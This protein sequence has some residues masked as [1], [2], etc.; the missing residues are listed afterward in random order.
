MQNRIDRPSA[1]VCIAYRQLSIMTG[2][3]DP[4]EQ[5]KLEETKPKNE[6][7]NG[8]IKKTFMDFTNIYMQDFFEFSKN[9]TEFIRSIGNDLTVSIQQ[10]QEYIMSHLSQRE[11]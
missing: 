1:I 8:I 9:M 7:T 3:K 2:I 11:Q 5:P 10:Y 6:Q 4:T